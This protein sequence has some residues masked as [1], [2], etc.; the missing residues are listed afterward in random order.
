MGNKGKNRKEIQIRGERRFE[1][2]QNIRCVLIKLRLATMTEKSEISKTCIYISGLNLISTQHNNVWQN[3]SQ[4]NKQ[5]KKMSPDRH[6]QQHLGTCYVKVAQLCLTL[7][8][9]MDCRQTGNPVHGIFQARILEW[10]D[11]SFSRG[12]SQPRDGTQVFGI[13]GRVFTCWAT[14]DL[15][16]MH[17]LGPHPELLNQNKGNGILQSS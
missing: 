2:V 16:G 3:P 4:I 11:I 14:R 13:A 1:G 6:H 15:L 7:C 8:N 12:S 17:I 9:P 10:V 5:T